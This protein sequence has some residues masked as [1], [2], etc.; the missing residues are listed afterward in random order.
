MRHNK[1]RLSRIT[2]ALGLLISTQTAFAQIS[3]DQAAGNLMKPLSVF[4]TVVYNVCYIL[5]IMLLVGA[6]TQYRTYRQN[7][8]QTPL[9]R[10]IILLL[11]ALA[12]AL[13]PFIAKLSASSTLFYTP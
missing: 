2:A 6:V 8:G 5:A 11:L 9:S 4:A 12:T 3:W 7:P 1:P 10:P 13:L